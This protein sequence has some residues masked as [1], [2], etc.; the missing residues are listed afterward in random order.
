MTDI[1]NFSFDFVM[2]ISVKHKFL[3]HCLHHWAYSMKREVEQNQEQQDN[4]IPRHLVNMT[5]RAI[6]IKI[7]IYNVYLG[8]G[9]R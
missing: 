5:A 1:D 7:F 8:F 4:H 3:R 6:D 9:V 2:F